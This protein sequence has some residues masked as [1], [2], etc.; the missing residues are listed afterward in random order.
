[1]SIPKYPYKW[2]WLEPIGQDI[3]LSDFLANLLLEKERTEHL[4]EKT[5]ALVQNPTIYQLSNLQRVSQ[6]LGDLCPRV[7]KFFKEGD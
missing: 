2:R 4:I 3:T 7:F 5:W 1:M 6:P